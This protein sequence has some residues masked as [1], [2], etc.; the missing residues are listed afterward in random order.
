MIKKDCFGSG[1]PMKVK[2]LNCPEYN[3][4]QESAKLK[5]KS[6]KK[7]YLCFASGDVLNPDVSVVKSCP[8]C[9]A[10]NDCLADSLPVDG[11][12]NHDMPTSPTVRTVTITITATDGMN[13]AEIGI[14]VSTGT[15]GDRVDN[16]ALALAG[17][18]LA[19]IMD[20]ADA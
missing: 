18:T 6:M 15:L 7:Q 16:H 11:P 2:C 19:A 1:D 5:A 17:V 12:E 3:Q 4:C 8:T 13:D 9:P 10:Y 20:H 14:K